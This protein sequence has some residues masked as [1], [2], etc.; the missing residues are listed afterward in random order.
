MGPRYRSLSGSWVDPEKQRLQADTDSDDEAPS[1]ISSSRDASS[2]FDP[3]L[4]KS[5]APSFRNSLPSL[6]Y[7]LPRRRFTRYFTCFIATS[8]IIFISLLVSASWSSRAEVVLG[9]KDPPAR[10][11]PWEQFPFLKRYHGGIRTLV[12]REEN[13]AKERG[14]CGVER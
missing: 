13:V 5:T 1:L 9:I 10:P 7:H 4:G 6:A 2:S 11:A 14:R 12:S 3:I 8:L